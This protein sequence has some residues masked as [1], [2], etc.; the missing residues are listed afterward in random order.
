MTII[1]ALLISITAFVYFYLKAMKALQM[2]QLN[3]YRNERYTKWMSENKSKVYFLSD[4]LP[5]FGLLGLLISPFVAAIISI[6]LFI[7]LI[8]LRPKT[9]EKKPLAVTNRVK[10]LIRTT[11]GLGIL[12]L[13]IPYLLLSEA[14]FFYFLILAGVMICFR[15]YFVVLLANVIN[16]PFEKRINDRFVNQAKAKIDDCKKNG[17]KVIG[18][19]GSYG[20]TSTK[21]FINQLLSHKYNTL[22][23]PGSYN[24]KIGVT[25]VANRDL[26]LLHEVFI[27]EM[28]AKQPNDIKELGELAQHEIAILTAIGPQHLE[29]FGSIDN[30]RK[31]KYELIDTL[32]DDGV[33]FFNYDNEIVRDCAR[34]TKKRN[35]T[36]SAKDKNADYYVSDLTISARGSKF[37]INTPNGSK[38]AI[39][40]KL[41]GE[42]NI[43]NLVA[44]VAVADELDVPHQQMSGVARTLKTAEHRL[45]IKKTAAGITI[46]DDAFNSNPVGSKAA[47]EILNMMEGNTKFLITPGMVELGDEE[48]NLNY[49]F[50]KYAAE[51]CDYIIL[52]GKKQTEPIQKALADV[53]FPPDKL[54]VA[55]DFFEGNAHFQTLA[56]A[57]DVVLYENDLPDT[58]NE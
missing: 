10:R 35:F 22:M 58:Y 8:Q 13:A 47:V 37:T 9:K 44:A 16:R 27:A 38:I 45:E 29:T 49:Q 34:V 24:T 41:L 14:W 5:L 46:I 19:T 32:S 1:Y 7:L 17:L 18:I 23:T 51:N 31:T 3:S 36:Y 57:G 25:L 50:G 12:L 39:E 40:T 52:V 53:N 30:V 15:T 21:Y 2:L 43:L 20:K 26:S 48:Y 6:A 11:L 54:F 33:A 55:K 56:K 4:I 42:L 28:G